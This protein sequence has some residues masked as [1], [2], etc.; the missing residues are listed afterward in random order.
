[1]SEMDVKALDANFKI[2]MADRAAGLSH[3]KAFERYVFEQVLKD[4]DPADEDIDVGDFAK[5]TPT[6]I[7]EAFPKLINVANEDM[8]FA[9]SRIL[10]VYTVHGGQL[11][12]KSSDMTAF[13][14]TALELDRHE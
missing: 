10:D 13:V 14:E 7:A 11:V 9:C 12:A 2:W 1:M 5:P 6:Q 4:H 8:D 3:S